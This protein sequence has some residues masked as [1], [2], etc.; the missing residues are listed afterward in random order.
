MTLWVL[1]SSLSELSRQPI[2][3]EYVEEVLSDH[4]L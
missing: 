4:V 3:P 1:I 2:A